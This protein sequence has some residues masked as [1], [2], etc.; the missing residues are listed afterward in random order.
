M[1]LLQ[2]VQ[3]K[4]LNFKFLGGNKPFLAERGVQKIQGQ[5]KGLVCR[6]FNHCSHSTVQKSS[7][8]ESTPLDAFWKSKFSNDK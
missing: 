6:I 4:L 2:V 1:F 7:D 5:L 8:N 3:E